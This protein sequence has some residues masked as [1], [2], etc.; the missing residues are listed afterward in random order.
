MTAANGTASAAAQNDTFPCWWRLGATKAEDSQLA[1]RNTARPTAKDTAPEIRADFLTRAR[2]RPCSP[3]PARMATRR[4][5]ATS[6]PNRV[7]VLAMN[8][9]WVVTMT[10]PN[11]A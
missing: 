6:M 1:K 2:T 8:A 3:R 9:N 7:A 4:T 10:T 5:L 11:N